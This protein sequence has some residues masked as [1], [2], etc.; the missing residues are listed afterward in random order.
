MGTRALGALATALVLSLSLSEA[1]LGQSIS[2]SGTVTATDGLPLEGVIVRSLGSNVH[3]VTAAD[4]KYSLT[5]ASDD[6]LNFSASGRRPIRVEIQGRGT[7]D[8]SLELDG[9]GW[10][11]VVPQGRPIRVGVGAQNHEGRFANVSGERIVWTT[12]LASDSVP[13]RQVN[14][15][16]AYAPATDRGIAIGAIAGAAVM[17]AFVAMRFGDVQCGV[18]C[19]RGMGTSLFAGG[20]FVGAMLGAYA[21]A[22]VGS[23]YHR[24]QRVH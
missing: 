17:T 13:V 6:V 11:A 9:L 21:G 2:V 14:Q 3:A 7:I 22:I 10:W 4:G 15:L 19:G 12:P 5:A 18:E 16:W 1:A 8:A 24:W 23:R 20:P